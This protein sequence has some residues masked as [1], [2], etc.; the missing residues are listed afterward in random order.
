MLPAR[1]EMPDY[2]IKICNVILF[3][4]QRQIIVYIYIY[5]TVHIYKI[6]IKYLIIIIIIKD[7]VENAKKANRN[8]KGILHYIWFLV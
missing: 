3:Y 1:C 4:D 6:L 5:I 7:D 8:H 2:N